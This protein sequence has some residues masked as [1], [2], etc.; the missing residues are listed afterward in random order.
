MKL[1]AATIDDAR[2]IAAVHVRSWQQ[3]YRD[4]LPTDLLANLS[5]D[6]RQAMWARAI[7]DAQSSQLVAEADGSVAGFLD[8][9]HC[10]DDGTSPKDYE[11]RAMY[12]APEYCSKGLGRHLWLASEQAMAALGAIH[13]S[14]WVLEGNLRGIRFY[15]AA[16]FRLDTGSAKSVELGGVQV[17]EVRCSRSLVR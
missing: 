13:V 1:R 3:A 5:I 11:I 2:A 4:L 8:Y 17:S 7:G 15:R 16:G 6:R 14:L 12:L 10:R 9:G